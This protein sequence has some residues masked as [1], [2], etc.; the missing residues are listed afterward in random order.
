[1]SVKELEKEIIRETSYHQT[2]GF[3][4]TIIKTLKNEKYMIKK[5]KEYDSII[6]FKIS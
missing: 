1:M 3:I 4:K 6:M 5:W 2:N